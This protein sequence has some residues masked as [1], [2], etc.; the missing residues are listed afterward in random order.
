MQ[1][2]EHHAQDIRAKHSCVPKSYIK[3]R[4]LKSDANNFRRHYRNETNL[5]YKRESIKRFLRSNTLFPSSNS[6]ALPLSKA[7]D[8]HKK[9]CPNS[10]QTKANIWLTC[11]TGL[12]KGRTS[13]FKLCVNDLNLQLCTSEDSSP[14]PCHRSHLMPN[15]SLI[16]KRQNINV[17]G[18][19]DIPI[20]PVRPYNSSNYV[21]I[22]SQ[23][24]H[25]KTYLSTKLRC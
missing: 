13:S 12:G 7:L 22:I 25:P 3:S 15:R 2:F 16:C 21:N 4:K 19:L 5:Q 17:S 11:K 14:A 8:D 20:H 18:H 6:S 24:Y 23:P 10:K 1:E 9:V